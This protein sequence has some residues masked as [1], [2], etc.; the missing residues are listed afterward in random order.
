MTK[1]TKKTLRVSVRRIVQEEPKTLKLP[2]TV[3]SEEP[4]TLRVPVVVISEKPK[5]L[6]VP[7]TVVSSPSGKWK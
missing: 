5:T 3:I 2:V 6:T 4:K 1:G 7:V